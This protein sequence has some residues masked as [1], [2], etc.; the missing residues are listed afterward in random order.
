MNRRA[1]PIAMFPLAQLLEFLVPTP[2]N[3]NSIATLECA[4]PP[5]T[6]G[7]GSAV[8]PF[9]VV[10]NEHFLIVFCSA[11]RPVPQSSNKHRRFSSKLLL[12]QINRQESVALRLAAGKMISPNAED[13]NVL[14]DLFVIVWGWVFETRAEQKV[15]LSARYDRLGTSIRECLLAE[16]RKTTTPLVSNRQPAGGQR[17]RASQRG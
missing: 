1:L 5:E 6:Y 11:D 17:R 12:G 4:G 14:V 15:C 10:N 13:R 3:Q 2:R 16:C 7:R 8:S 9:G